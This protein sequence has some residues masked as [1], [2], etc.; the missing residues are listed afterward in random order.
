MANWENEK[1]A[2]APWK[3]FKLG[4]VECVR[5]ALKV[6]HMQSAPEKLMQYGKGEE[7]MGNEK[8]R[9]GEMGIPL[10]LFCGHFDLQNCCKQMNVHTS[11]NICNTLP[12]LVTLSGTFSDHS[13]SF[14]PTDTSSTS[15]HY[16]IILNG[17]FR[18][19]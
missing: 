13:V 18:N 12:Q 11:G 6:K 1:A 9:K 8:G 2:C 10:R 16:I 5:I 4:L 19:S 17:F 14:W 15:A 3:T 7:E